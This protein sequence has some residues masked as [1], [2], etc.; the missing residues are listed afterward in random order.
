MTGKMFSSNK[1]RQK[2]S[3]VSITESLTTLRVKKFGSAR[4][5]FEFR[6]CVDS[7][8]KDILPLQ[9]IS[10]SKKVVIVKGYLCM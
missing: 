10:V 7:R 3:V 8:Q 6:K 2:D 5:A 9:W 4:E 1:K